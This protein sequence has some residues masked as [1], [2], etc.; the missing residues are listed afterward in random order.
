MSD[1]SAAIAEA[2]SGFGLDGQVPGGPH[3]DADLFRRR[4]GRAG[5][6]EKT[7]RQIVGVA[8]ARR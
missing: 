3:T 5:A 4:R 7:A 8:P 2:N 6:A 1:W